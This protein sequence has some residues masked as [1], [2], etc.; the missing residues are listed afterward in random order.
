MIYAVP[1]KIRLIAVVQLREL[2]MDHFTGRS[3]KVLFGTDSKKE[4]GRKKNNQTENQKIECDS[5]G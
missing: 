3:H 2:M 1:D 5:S 4:R